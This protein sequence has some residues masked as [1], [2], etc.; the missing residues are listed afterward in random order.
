MAL[1]FGSIITVNQGPAPVPGTAGNVPG[2]VGRVKRC[3]NWVTAAWVMVPG[4]RFVVPG[5][6]SPVP[7]YWRP[8]PGPQSPGQTDISSR[9]MVP[10][11][12]P[13]LRGP[14]ISG[15]DPR[16]SHQKKIFKA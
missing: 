11:P 7:G 10:G 1:F 16:P 4:P 6:W 2:I 8:V 15:Q 12:G 9:V 13:S 14:A 5:S 3:R